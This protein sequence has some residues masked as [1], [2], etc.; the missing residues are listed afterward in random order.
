MRD[1]NYFYSIDHQRTTSIKIKRSIFIC[2]LEYVTTIEQAKKF[3]TRISKENKTATHNC[4]AYIIGEK[5]D[6]FHCSDAGEPSGTAGKPML[7]TMVSQRMTQIAAVVT[8]HFG[9][10]KLGVPGLIK[11]YGSCVKHTL[12]LKPL[13]KLIVS[14][15]IYIEVSYEFND[16]LMAQ[17]KNYLTRINDTTYTDKII[18]RVEIELKDH[19]KV[20]GLLSQY[21]SQKKIKFKVNPQP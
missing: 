9:G 4:W 11:A 14:M 5:G 13:K 3:I 7:N 2:T 20:C 16:I 1:E 10:V 17:I 18:Y 6:Y 8:R 19:V 15:D 21:Q 12:D